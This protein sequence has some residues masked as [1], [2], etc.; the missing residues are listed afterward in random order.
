MFFLIST[1]SVN[2]LNPPVKRQILTEWRKKKKKKTH[3]IQP[4]AETHFRSKDTIRLKAKRWEKILHVNIKKKRE[5]EKPGVTIPT[6]DKIY[7]KSKLLQKTKKD[8]IYWEKSLKIYEVNTDT[9]EGRNR[10]MYNTTRWR[11]WH[12]TL[13]NGGNNQTE[14]Q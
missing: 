7:C 8:I 12:S 9:N 6:S 13:S 11:L 1:L 3:I 4:Y 2:R 5:R 10:P 14:G